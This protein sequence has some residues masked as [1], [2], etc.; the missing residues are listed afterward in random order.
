MSQTLYFTEKGLV[1]YQAEIQKV[2]DELTALQSRIADVAETG[3]NQ[4]HDNASYDYVTAEIR[5]NDK[6]L[7]DMIRI[8][9]QGTVVSKTTS[10]ECVDIGTKVKVLWNGDE[11]EWQIGGYGESDFDHNVIAYNTPLASL[12]MGKKGGETV[13][14]EIARRKV[15]IQIISI[16]IS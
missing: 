1:K 12:I 3:G 16:N 2:Q 6:R 4:W 9:R 15:T 8:L 5:Q 13:T 11:Q 10:N 14:G 7:G